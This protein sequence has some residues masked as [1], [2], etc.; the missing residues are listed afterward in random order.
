MTELEKL[1][2]PRLNDHNYVFWHI[3]MRAYLVARG[4]SAAITNAED[5]NSDKALASITLAVE[6]HFLPTVYNAASAKAAW[7]ALEALFQ[8][9]SVANQLNL[10]QE[11]NNLTLQPGE[12]ITQLLARAR[13][14]WEQLK[15]AGIDKS[16]QE[17]ALSVLSGL[18]A[19]FNTLVT[20]LQNQSGPLTLGGIQKAVLTEQ[21]RA[22]KVGAS[23]STA[24]STKAFYTQNGPNHGRLGDSGT[25][26]SN[27]NQG[28]GNTKQQEQRKCYYCGKKGHLKRDCRKKKADEQRGPSTKASTT[29][30]WTAACNTSISLSSG[31]W[32]LDSGASRHV[33]KER[34]LMQN[35]QQLNQ[36]VYI[37]YGNGSTGVA[38]TM[39][40]VVLNDR[41]RLRNVLFD[42]TAVGNLLSIRTA[43]ACGAQFNFAASCCTIRVN[44]RLVA[45]AQQHDGHYCLHSE[46]TESATALA[47]Q[48]PQLWHRRFGHLSYQNMAKVP[49]LV[50]GV[51]VP[52]EAF[53]AAGQQVCEPCLL[54]KQTRLSFPESETV[55]QQPL[56]LV[57]MDLCG[58]LP[59]KSLG[60][61]QYI[62]TFLDD[63]TGL[64]VVALLKQKS[65]ISKVVPDVFNMLEKQSN[66]QV[67]GVRTDNG[68]EYVNNVL[69]SYYSSKGIIAQHTVPYSPQQNGK[70]ERLNRTLLDK[71]RSM[72]AD[73][74]LPSQLW[75][76]AVVTA[77][78][79]RNRS[80]A[81]GKTATPWEL[82]FGSRPSVSHLR[83]FGAKA[84]A[85]IPK[86]KRGK[87]DPR[88]QRGIMVGY[89]PNVKGYR[90]LLPNNTITV[91]RDV[92]FD[93]GDQPGAVDTN[94]YPDLEDELDV[95]AA[96]NTGS[97][98]APSVNT[99]GTAEPPPSVAAPVNPPI[100]AQTMENVGASNS[101]TPQGSEEDQHQQSRRSSRAN[102]GM[103]PGNY[104]EANYIPTSKRTATGLLAQTSEIVEPATYDEA[105]QSDC[106]EQWQ[107]A[108]DSEYASL[109]ANGTWT[110]EKPPTDIRPIPVKWVYKVKRD[111]SGNIERFKARLVAK[112]FWQQEGV[113]YDEVFAPVSKYATFRA[114]MAKAAEEDMELHKLDVKTAFLQGNLEEDVWIQQPRG[115]EEGSSEL[116]C[117]LHKPLYGLKQ[118]PRAWHQ[119]LQQELL[120][121]GYTASAADPSLYWYCINGDY[122]YL[123]V[124]VDDILI[125][126]KQLESVK[127]VKQQLLG[128]FESRDLGEATSYLGMSIQRNRQTGIIKIGHRL[129]ITELL[130]KYGAVDSKIKSVP[131][132]PS[133]KLAKDEGDPLDKEHY[134]YSQL[135][136]SLMYLAI[137]SRPDLAFSVGAL[138]R[139][140]S[141]PTT[142]HWQAAKGVLRYLGGTLDYG[143]T[144]GSDSND[145]IGYC[146]ADYAGDTDTRKSTSG[147]IFIL[148]GGAITWS[149]KRQATV[150]AST[151]EAEYMAA[152]AAVKE[153]LWLRTLLSELQLDIDNITIMADNQSAI[154]L[155]RNPISSMRTK[156]IDVAYHFARERVVRKE[157]VFRFVSTENMVADIMTK[158]LS[159]VKHV[160][161]CKGMGVGV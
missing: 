5:A 60:G 113:D 119:R 7:D 158:A 121:V 50:T 76:E 104:W 29:M 123:L 149:S 17:V 36:P 9:R 74:R 40:E 129:M 6:D 54:G 128:L 22:N 141:C 79:L 4:Y 137:T 64:S 10:T 31:T 142:V 81:A 148:H 150:A 140:M 145:L 72:L 35:L 53:Q 48:T 138:A 47:A 156:H 151:T 97:N 91:S 82:F 139:Y 92:V 51:Q 37:T 65:D 85:Q 39:G 87:L 77:N 99:S 80:P 144:F 52:T 120:A 153:A 45:I 110:L 106:A 89:E 63:Y 101:S 94:F 13:I 59:V 161:C 154:K 107:Q 102:I 1:G 38:Q 155:L 68:G 83:V 90:L 135:V 108:M 152:A 126:A 27:F 24:A 98:A 84:F 127:A 133:I 88:S 131:L 21:Q 62:A 134:P 14:I 16:E 26:T 96:I 57:H 86:E 124:Y 33:C 136:G 109:I 100:S 25:R 70:A 71:A 19:D 43:A 159:E 34:S 125:A 116:A 23:T 46:H 111:T 130:E 3:K 8:Q 12:T 115:Y 41:I 157:V 69:N 95:T 2:I 11:L 49:N 112:G 114:L 55:R 32:V 61:S 67:K 28:N 143:I 103:A 132:S 147:Y 93:E 44:G 78:Y 20:V 56:E 73:A 75:G 117:H 105:L 146:D 30:A 18:P 58:P 122:V 42:P 160:R 66:N 118:A 15:A